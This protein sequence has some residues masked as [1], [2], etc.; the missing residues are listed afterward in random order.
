MEHLLKTYNLKITTLKPMWYD[1]FYV[2][3][4]SEK[5]KTGKANIIKAFWN[6]FISNLKAM[7]GKTKCSSLIYVIAKN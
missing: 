3:M 5:C 4:L 1:S 6:G 7:G 2:S